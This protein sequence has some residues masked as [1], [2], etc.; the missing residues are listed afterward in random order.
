[1]PK[2]ALVVPETTHKN[3]SIPL[4]FRFSNRFRW[5]FYTFIGVILYHVATLV[6]PGYGELRQLLEGDLLGYLKY[7]IG[8][9]FLFE[10]ISVAIFLWLARW[11]LQKTAIKTLRPTLG[12]L[13]RLELLFLPL[14][15]LSI[16]LFGPVTN[17]VRYLVL[18][19]PD[20]SWGEYFP[21]YFFTGRMYV[22]YLLPFLIFGYLFFN[23]NLF[24]D[25]HEWQK[26]RFEGLKSSLKTSE[27][28]FLKTV[29]ARDDQGETLL[30]TSNVLWFEVDEKNYMAI[31]QGKT[32]E[33]RKTITELEA[34]L[35]PDAFFRVNRSV[36]INLRFLKNYSF[37]EHD[38]YIL[39]LS[40]DKTTFVMQR[41]RLKDLKKRLGVA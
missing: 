19:Y 29:E 3:E 38:K 37:W 39:R 4:S 6:R 10:L 7:F 20:Y 22:N 13:L 15:L 36:I 14:I 18:F 16:C 21:E 24:L 5:L 25:Y 35:N 31:T 23:V 41:T 32:Y 33:I 26:K 12:D 34:E 28:T 27:N 8:Y 30:D 1:M 9:Y 11:Y 17:A 2:I 40:D